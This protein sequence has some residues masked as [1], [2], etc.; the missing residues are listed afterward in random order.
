MRVGVL[1]LPTDPWPKTAER[2][3]ELEA[4]GYDHLWTY[5]HLSWYR[6]HE[7]PWYSTLTWWSASPA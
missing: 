7:R 1:L 3:R 6:Y 2:V 5:D 4:M